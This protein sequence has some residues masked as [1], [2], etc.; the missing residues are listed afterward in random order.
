MCLIFCRTHTQKYILYYLVNSN[1]SNTFV[2]RLQEIKFENNIKTYC[3][4]TN[5]SF[6]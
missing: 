6:C 4:Y 2:E 3:K 5:R 1:I